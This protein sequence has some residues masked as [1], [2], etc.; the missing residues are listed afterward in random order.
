MPCPMSPGNPS[1]PPPQLH[2]PPWAGLNA[3]STHLPTPGDTPLPVVTAGVRARP[4][5]PSAD[6]R[7]GR[8]HGP[9]PGTRPGPPE[10]F[11]SKASTVS[12]RQATKCV[13]APRARL[14]PHLPVGRPA[15]PPAPPHVGS[16]VAS[17]GAS[18]KLPGGAA[19][20]HA[21]ESRTRAAAHAPRRYTAVR[22]AG[23]RLAGCPGPRPCT[24]HARLCTP[25]RTRVSGETRALRT[26]RPDRRAS[27]PDGPW[28]GSHGA[29]AVSVDGD[30][31][32]GAW[33]K[34]ASAHP[35]D[36]TATSSWH[37]TAVARSFMSS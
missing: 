1:R 23:R 36:T 14:R 26:G 15:R 11:A 2:T 30:R 4:R 17:S 6:P 3:V 5:A 20:R 32:V 28:A 35:R 7:W 12:S 8:R 29:S 22:S 31:T 10:A 16:C 19:S 13:P 37:R 18:S 33:A 24:R 25:Q 21:G 34:R 27:L 9:P